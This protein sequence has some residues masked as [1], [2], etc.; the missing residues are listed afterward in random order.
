MKEVWKSIP[1][2]EEWYS[3]STMGN[4]RREKSASAT[5]KGRI[6]S[7]QLNPRGYSIVSINNETNRKKTIK[8]SYLV[9]LTFL[10]LRIDG[11]VINHKNGIKIDDRL[12]NLE[13]VTQSMNVKHAYD[14]LGHKA[15]HGKTHW[16][17]KKTECKRGH[18]YSFDNTSISN[19]RRICKKCRYINKKLR[20]K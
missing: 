10:G 4:I 13:Y 11:H 15:P 5:K 14:V 2:Y 12:S 18:L 16:N 1:G 9:A 6:L 19:G 17:S 20:R 3:V 7:K 8:V